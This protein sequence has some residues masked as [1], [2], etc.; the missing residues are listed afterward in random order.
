MASWLEFFYG[1]HRELGYAG[2]PVHDTVAVAALIAPELFRMEEMY[3][4]VETQGTYCRGATI[5]DRYHL[6]GHAPNARVIL[7]LDRE[8]F[9]DL[10]TKAAASYS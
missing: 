7:D 2:A 6:S 3:V 5:G 8:G 1:F 10:L 4:A 9:V